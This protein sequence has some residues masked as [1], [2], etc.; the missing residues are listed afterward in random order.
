MN[1]GHRSNPALWPAIADRLELLAEGRR[2]ILITTDTVRECVAALRLAPP[3]PPV[4]RLTPPHESHLINWDAVT[5]GAPLACELC[6][7]RMPDGAL[8]RPCPA[9]P[10]QNAAQI[11]YPGLDL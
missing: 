8:T 3:P 4:R 6:D 1:S 11:L 5:A 2:E 9:R 10:A 7:A